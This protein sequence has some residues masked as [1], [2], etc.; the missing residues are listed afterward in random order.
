MLKII[1]NERVISGSNGGGDPDADRA[2]FMARV[3][4][5]L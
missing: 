3:I 5:I 2:V 1:K 4:G